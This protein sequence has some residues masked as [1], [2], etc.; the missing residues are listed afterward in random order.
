MQ[1]SVTT[2][3]AVDASSNLSILFRVWNHAFNS[4]ETYMPLYFSLS[5]FA[6]AYLYCLWSGKRYNEM[7]SLHNVHNVGVVCFG[8]IGLGFDND[9]VLKERTLGLF[10]MGYFLVDLV[11]NIVHKDW[12][13]TFHA[14]C[15][16]IVGFINWTD[17]LCVALR[18]QSKGCLMEFSSPFLHLAKRTRKPFHFAMFAASFTLCRIIWIPMIMRELY[19][20]N[21]LLRDPKFLLI[22]AFYGLNVFW[23][24]KILRILL[25]GSTSRGKEKKS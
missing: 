23:Y 5:L 17:P 24:Y 21:V 2:E 19:S 14:V 22:L 25:R 16:L 1:E 12:A 9:Q 3:L 7:A 15:C 18:M 8:A 4:N 6:S 20:H 13:Y 10:S 11:E